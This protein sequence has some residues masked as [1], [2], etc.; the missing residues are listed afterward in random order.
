MKKKTILIVDDEETVT[1]SLSMLLGDEYEVKSFTTHTCGIDSLKWLEENNVDYAIVDLLINGVSGIDITNVLQKKDKKARI[2]IITGCST[3]S[4]E[5]A[6]AQEMT[7]TNSNIKMCNKPF[8]EEGVKFTSIIRKDL[9]ET[10][11]A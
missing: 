1:R 7:I 8:N 2:M 3:D 6:K 11:A 5:Y 9:N 4:K 10:I